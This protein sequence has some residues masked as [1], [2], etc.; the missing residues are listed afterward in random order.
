MVASR[1]AQSAERD[2]P[3]PARPPSETMPID[4]SSSRSSADAAARRTDRGV[5]NA[6]RSPRTSLTVLSGLT[7]RAPSRA[8]SGSPVRCGRAGAPPPPPRAPRRRTGPATCSSVSSRSPCR[9]TSGR[10]PGRAGTR[11][12]RDPPRP[13]LTRSGMSLLTSVT[14]RPSAASPSATERIRVSFESLRKP[15]GSTLWSAWFELDPQ[16][17][18]LVVA[19]HRVIQPAVLDAQ[20]VEHAQRLPGEPAELGMVTLALQL[21]DHHERDDDLVI[22]EPAERR[23]IGQQD[24]GVQ[25]ENPPVGAVRSQ[26]AH[27]G[28]AASCGGVLLEA[29][30]SV[31]R[32]VTGLLQRACNPVR[33]RSPRP[34]PMSCTGSD[35]GPRGASVAGPGGRLARDDPSPCLKR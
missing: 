14:S 11:P 24:R 34:A 31:R 6:S 22:G 2:L 27:P 19:Q 13:A 25:N 1:P 8:T 26:R 16:R 20:L 29:L 17:S 33:P 32:D 15:C 21:G 30:A 28:R 4:S 23:R 7:R 3:V 5:P 18:A 9:S 10:W 12:R 35:C